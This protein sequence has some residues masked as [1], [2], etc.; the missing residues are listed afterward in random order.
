MVLWVENIRR[1]KESSDRLAAGHAT[2]NAL[3]HDMQMVTS[4]RARVSALTAV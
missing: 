1:K 4:I 3:A 2:I